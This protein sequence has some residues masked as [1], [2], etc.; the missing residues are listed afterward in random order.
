MK[1][2]RV[3][4]WSKMDRPPVVQKC[5]CCGAEQDPRNPQG[6]SLKTMRFWVPLDTSPGLNVSPLAC[7]PCRVKVA[8]VI[9]ETVGVT[10]EER[11]D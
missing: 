6:V 10:E 3:E 4:D 1:P 8:R 11:V 9:E 5:A 7:L 2:L